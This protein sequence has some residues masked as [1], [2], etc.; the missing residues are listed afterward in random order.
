MTERPPDPVDAETESQLALPVVIFQFVFE[1]MLMVFCSPDAMKLSEEGDTVSV[2]DAPCCVT[3][4]SCFS[5]F[6]VASTDS[7][8]VRTFVVRFGSTTTFKVASPIPDDVGSRASHVA[9]FRVIAQLM[10]ELT[11]SGCWP[12]DAANCKAAVATDRLR[13]AAPTDIWM[14]FDSFTPVPET[15]TVTV[16][17]VV[18]VFGAAVT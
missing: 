9:P 6:D 8:A 1:V 2:G 3:V 16:R 13:G 17:G 7:T 14:V 18:C 5:K 11:V 15:V 12:P 4:T 10:L